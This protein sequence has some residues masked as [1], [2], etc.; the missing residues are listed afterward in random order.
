MYAQENQGEIETLSKGITLNEDSVSTVAEILK[1]ENSNVA[2]GYHSTFRQ[3]LKIIKLY[4]LDTRFAY[5]QNF[6]FFE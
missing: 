5:S 3:N 6:L 2:I 4:V 1:N